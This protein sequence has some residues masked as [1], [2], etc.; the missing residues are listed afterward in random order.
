MGE[1]CFI[2]RRYWVVKPH[3]SNCGRKS[4]RNSQIKERRCQL[5][6]CKGREGLSGRTEMTLAEDQWYFQ[7]VS[8]SCGVVVRLCFCSKHPVSGRPR[9][10]RITVSLAQ[11]TSLGGGGWGGWGQV[12][13]PSIALFQ[14]TPKTRKS[15]IWGAQIIWRYSATH[16]QRR[17]LTFNALITLFL[18]CITAPW[19]HISKSFQRGQ[20][21]RAAIARPNRRKW[22]LQNPPKEQSRAC[23][24]TLMPLTIARSYL[25]TV[26][27][28]KI[29]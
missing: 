12:W 9:R 15:I 4:K 24:L 22:L 28:C 29:R 3:K 8:E 5:A 23:V 20:V 2:M 27:T 19:L 6:L 10:R 26:F 25:T 13:G 21:K 11:V 14:T 17:L 18:G 7:S 1:K 16:L